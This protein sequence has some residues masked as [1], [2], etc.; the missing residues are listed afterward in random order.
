MTEI[1]PF[2]F[3]DMQMRTVSVDGEPWFVGADVCRI[4]D[5]SNVSMA[6]AGLDAD[7]VSTTEVID[8]LG[9]TQRA[10]II[11]ESGLY[12]LIL[13]SRKSEAKAIKRWV[14]H[15]VLPTIRRTG[16][17][18]TPTKEPSRL[19]LIDIARAAEL[20]RIAEHEARQIAEA[21]VVELAPKAAYVDT[22]VSN[23]D[24]TTIRDAANRLGIAEHDLRDLLT[25]KK[26]IYK[27]SIGRRFSETAGKLVEEWEYRA[28]A[29]HR[30]HFRLIPQHKA[31]RHHNNQVRQT[32]YITP[33]GF[34]AVRR[35]VPNQLASV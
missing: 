35:L 9:R 8:S 30:E 10:G 26:W 20:E 4:L 3:D 7:E 6:L 25:K 18:G 32:L 29:A 15:E 16:S 28:Y 27:I 5:L 33:V 17:F 11:S 13:R 12:S 23:D 19:E 24:L 21:K 2:Q 14:T 1:T 34:V 22:F 31:P